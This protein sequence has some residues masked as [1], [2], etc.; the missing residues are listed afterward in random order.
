MKITA[1]DQNF[2]IKKVT[3]LD[4]KW[5]DVTTPPLALHGVIFIRVLL[6]LAKD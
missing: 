6:R 1:I 3:E 2:A 5:Y 4:V